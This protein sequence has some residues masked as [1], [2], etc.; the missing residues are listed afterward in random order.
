MLV[1]KE[2]KY[3]QYCVK[4]I[5]KLYRFVSVQGQKQFTQQGPIQSLQYVTISISAEM[6]Y[7]KAGL[8]HVNG[9]AMM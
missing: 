3:G 7:C 6:A 2:N 8:A 9:L 5:N 1:L 4:T